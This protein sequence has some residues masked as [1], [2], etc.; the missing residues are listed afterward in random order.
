VSLLPAL[1]GAAPLLE[2][3]AFAEGLAGGPL[4]AAAVLGRQKLIVFN[5]EEP[6]AP[7]NELDGYLWRKD[8]SRLAL[9]FRPCATARG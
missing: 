9:L 7:A 4:R 6:F 1:T 5:R 3:P 8:L 2:R